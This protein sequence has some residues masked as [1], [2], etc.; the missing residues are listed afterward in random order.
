MC[1]C[2]GSSLVQLLS[3]VR[4]GSHAQF[5]IKSKA[6]ADASR[7]DQLAL[8]FAASRVLYTLCYLADRATLR[9]LVWF[10]VIG[11]IVSLFVIAA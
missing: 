8:A 9:S 7:F 10:A 4:R 2:L 1:D 6:V 5:R 3:P 11:L